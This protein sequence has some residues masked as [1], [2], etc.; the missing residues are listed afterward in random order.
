[1]NYCPY[2]GA[3]L[4][5]PNR[6]CP[7]CGRL[8]DA[9]T[10]VT[11]P[12]T[13]T[14]TADVTTGKQRK[15]RMSLVVL[16]VIGGVVL[17]A[18][19]AVLLINQF[20]YPQGIGLNST[21]PSTATET[22]DLNTA[23]ESVLYLEVYEKDGTMTATASGFIVK[24]GT[25]LVT[26]YHVVKNA[27]Y[28]I[29]RTPDG[30]KSVDIKTL[31][32]YNHVA[33]VAVLQC[34][35][36]IGVPPLTL[37]DS[38]AVQKGDPVYAVGYPLGLAHTISDGIISSK[39][40]NEDGYEVL[41]TT[42]PISSGSSGGAL[43]TENG[44][45]VGVICA[46]YEDGQNLNLAIASNTVASVLKRNKAT[47]LADLYLPTYSVE[48]V[49]AHSEELFGEDFYVCGWVSEC[50]YA[51]DG[52]LYS[53]TIYGSLD[54]ALEV[55]HSGR[56]KTGYIIFRDFSGSEDGGQ[57]E[58][59]NYVRIKGYFSRYRIDYDSAG[60]ALEWVEVIG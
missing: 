46:Y 23:A 51:H 38:N 44:Q 39:Y 37:G 27:Y 29:A 56:D 50:S 28:I 58:I 43:L 34:E 20:V 17:A 45:V 11:E 5:R 30:E 12:T 60:M 1:M 22:V 42:A 53:V 15:K 16:A 33:D 13:P 57:V 19:L 2:C 36:D 47:L 3:S 18:G 49:L 35:K 14:P 6:F 59:G 7:N 54:E 48:Y 40:T 25:T 9:E 10:P 24:D 8:L 26:N 41:Q 21:N 55:A 4:Q 31:L 52:H 32:A